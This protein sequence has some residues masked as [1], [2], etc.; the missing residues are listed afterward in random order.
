M[1]AS[2]AVTGK[3][4]DFLITQLNQQLNQQVPTG[5]TVYQDISLLDTTS[6]AEFMTYPMQVSST[7]EVH[8]GPT[9][10]R[11]F[12]DAQVISLQCKVG[13]ID[14][15]NGVTISIS[16][17]FDP[18][19]IVQQYSGDLLRQ[20]KKMWDREL[21]KTILKNDK[22]YDG[23]PFF[24]THPI[25]PNVVGTGTFI[26]DINADTTE[27]GVS[28]ALDYFISGIRQWDGTRINN[29]MGVPIFL[30]P[31]LSV[32]IALDKLFNEG[33]IAQ[34]VAGAAASSNTRLVGYGRTVHMSELDDPTDPLAKRRYYI[35]N[36]AY[37]MRRAFITRIAEQP[38]L[39]MTGPMDWL[40]HTNDA[41]AFYYRAIGGTGYGLPQLA[42]RCTF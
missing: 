10:A 22:A 18:Y 36:N 17:A 32:K 15:G 6:T 24:G 21:A 33:L 4:P 16:K 12:G 11:K 38:Q 31:T 39:I 2:F 1:P 19:E 14:Q 8:R 42:L 9:E 34:P 29:D 7:S 3:N 37:G 13:R 35:I 28:G 30:C 26:N 27:A 40:A 20:M 25:N 23:Q 5:D 41:R